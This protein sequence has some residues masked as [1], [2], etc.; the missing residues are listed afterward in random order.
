MVPHP[1]VAANPLVRPIREVEIDTPPDPGTGARVKIMDRLDFIHAVC[2]QIPEAELHQVRYYAAYSCKKRRARVDE[3][4]GK[5]DGERLSSAC[6]AR[7]RRRVEVPAD[8]VV[9]PD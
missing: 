4:K 2:Q 6:R 1:A 8:R 7:R 5:I 3:E 9:R